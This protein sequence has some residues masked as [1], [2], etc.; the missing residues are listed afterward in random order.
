MAL[1]RCLRCR[2]L[3]GEVSL[4]LQPL[5]FS[6]VVVSH[7]GISA[8]FLAHEFFQGHAFEHSSC[9]AVRINSFT[10]DLA[11]HKYPFRTSKHSE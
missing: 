4:H 6:S 10:D 9:K 8:V 11:A 5:P 2:G 7:F 1:A 3:A